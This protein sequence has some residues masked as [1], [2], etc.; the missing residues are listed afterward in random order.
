VD[1]ISKITPTSDIL[2]Y[3]VITVTVSATSKVRC[4]KEKKEEISVEK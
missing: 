4:L 1:P 2:N 3:R